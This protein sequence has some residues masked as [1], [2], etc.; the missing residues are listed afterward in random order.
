MLSD[1]EVI[2]EPLKMVGVHATGPAGTLAGSHHGPDATAAARAVVDEALQRDVR[3][4]VTELLRQYDD[5]VVGLSL[6][7]A[8]AVTGGR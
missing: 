5:A 8:L 4:R 3:P 6:A 2:M 1:F 7:G